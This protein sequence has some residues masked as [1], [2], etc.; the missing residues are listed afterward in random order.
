MDTP[1]QLS[2]LVGVMLGADAVFLF[3]SI[4]CARAIIRKNN[5]EGGL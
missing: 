3:A 4:L 2:L 5:R 1:H